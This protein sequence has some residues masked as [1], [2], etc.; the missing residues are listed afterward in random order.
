VTQ[1]AAAALDEASDRLRCLVADPHGP[2]VEFLRAY[3]GSDRIAVTATAA[4][5]DEA[6]AKIQAQQPDVAI[7]ALRLPWLD[8]IEV[9]RTAARVA[10]RTAILLQARYDDRAAVPEALEAGARGVIRADATPAAVRNAIEAVMAGSAYVDSLLVAPKAPA[11]R[12]R[13]TR[14][15]LDVLSL[16][17]EGFSNTDISYRLDISPATVRVHIAN[18]R[19]KLH[20]ANRA[21]AVATA[22]RH[23]LI[24]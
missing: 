4:R 7:V 16:V 11:S 2:N 10:P 21:H 14:R 5:G 1:L 24:H 20:A 23:E 22:F 8:G 19:A 17:A 12:L 6:L 3:L 13:V 18:A 15:E 9:T